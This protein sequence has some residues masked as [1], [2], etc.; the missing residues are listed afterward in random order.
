MWPWSFKLHMR[1]SKPTESQGED[2]NPSSLASAMPSPLESFPNGRPASSSHLQ[3]HFFFCDKKPL[4]HLWPTSKIAHASRGFR[5]LDL[6]TSRGSRYFLNNLEYVYCSPIFCEIIEAFNEHSKLKTW[7][8]KFGVYLV[9]KMATC[10]DCRKLANPSKR[11]K[12]QGNKNYPASTSLLT[13]NM[14][15]HVC[16]AYY[17]MHFNFM[18]FYL[19]QPPF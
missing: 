11:R 8:V 5:T 9:I 3:W 17:N 19:P 6:L 13:C 15:F 10:I 4:N 16:S 1:K 7:S 18:I 12:T 14:S 2:Q